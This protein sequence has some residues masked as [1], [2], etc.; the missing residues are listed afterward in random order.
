MRTSGEGQFASAC[1]GVVDIG[2]HIGAQ[3]RPPRRAGRGV[4]ERGR[5]SGTASA[6]RGYT[7]PPRARKP[8]SRIRFRGRAGGVPE[9]PPQERGGAGGR[10]RR[11]P[12]SHARPE[13][14]PNDSGPL[15]RAVPEGGFGTALL[16]GSVT[17]SSSWTRSCGS[18]STARGRPGRPE[19]R[20]RCSSSSTGSRRSGSTRSGSTRSGSTRTGSSST[21]RSRCPRSS[22]R[23]CCSA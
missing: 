7:R 15:A 23:S 12:R 22:G 20:S 18:S 13:P 4:L 1:P 21:G 19:S 6:N 8:L 9:A 2:H 5:K 17:W 16:G 3:S 14:C 11:P 10:D